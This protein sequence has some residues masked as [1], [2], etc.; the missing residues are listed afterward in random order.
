MHEVRDFMFGDNILPEKR[1]EGHRLSLR[2]VQHHAE[3]EPPR[4]H[5]G[6]AIQLHVTTSGE[7][8]FERVRVFYTLNGAAPTLENALTLDLGAAQVTWDNVDWLYIRH[9]QGA[10]PGQ[11]DDTLIRYRVGAQVTGSQ[12]WV[13]ADKQGESLETAVDFAIWVSDLPAPAWAQQARVY[14]VFVDRFY[15]GDGKSWKQPEWLDGFYGGSL[16]GVEE[17]LDYIQTL[18]YNT[19]WLSPIFPSP[20]H[21]GYDATDM[22]QVEPRLGTTQDLYRLIEAAHQRGMRLILDFVA[23]HWSNLHPSMLAAQKD[24]SREYHHWYVW[25]KW[26]DEYESFFGVKSMPKL[27]LVLGSPARQHL[28]DCARFWLA[29][30]I[31]GYRLDYA[32]GPPLDF[33]VDFRRACKQTRPDSW[34]F[35]EVIM[36]APIQKSFA[37]AFDGMID[38][39]LAECTRQTFGYEH[40]SLAQFDA[41]LD[42]HEGYFQD[43]FDRLTILD[44]HDMNRFLFLAGDDARRLKL[45]ALVLYTLPGNPINYYGTE[46]GVTQ[47]LPTHHDDRG[48]FEEARQPMR[49]GAGADQDLLDYFQRLLALRTAHPALSTGSRRT[50]H[51]DEDRQTYAY[52]REAAG[53][54]L[55]VA[56]N[57]SETDQRLEVAVS[58]L[59]GACDLLNACPVSSSSAAISLVLPPKSGAVIGRAGSPQI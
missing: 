24:R 28:L 44:N 19:I 38:F 43:M 8:P 31:D 13:F 7:Q 51:L 15:P 56:L 18:G 36:S 2:G 26:P 30:G 25:K 33:W 34:L 9:W 5:S 58:G 16:R 17:K 48:F 14:H 39:L 22:Y 23:N 42:G 35:G 37:G 27:N 52:L 55:V 40:W 49:W 41:Y 11:P 53:E 54:R 57:R 47:E 59:D 32:Y 50:L 3:V 4:P 6:E 21:H 45:G 1:L 46:S 20:S 12:R 10:L 29:K